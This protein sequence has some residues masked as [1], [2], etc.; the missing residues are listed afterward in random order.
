MTTRI[1]ASLSLGMAFGLVA[2]YPV[3]AA[4]IAALAF[5]LYRA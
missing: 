1:F 4:A 3:H 2:V 5:W